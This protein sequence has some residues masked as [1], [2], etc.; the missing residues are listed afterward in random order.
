MKRI[1]VSLSE[2]KPNPYKKFI[3]GGEVDD[4]VVAQIMES[5][6]RTSFWEQW[7]VRETEKGYQLAFGHN[8]LA[9]AKQILGS[10]AK[11]SVQL[12]NYTDSQMYI[13]MADE[14]AGD[15]ESIAHQ[16]DVVRKAKELLIKNTEW[17]KNVIASHRETESN[18]KGAGAPH[19]HGS[20][21]CIQEFLGENNWSRAKVGRLHKLAEQA[22]KSVL[23]KVIDS[24][25]M[26]NENVQAGEI[27]QRAAIA[28]ADLDAPVQRAAAEVIKSAA[29]A[30]PT[31]EIEA[32]VERIATLPSAKQEAAVKREL[33]SKE[34]VQL[35]KKAAKDAKKAAKANGKAVP[36]VPEVGT[37]LEGLG[38]QIKGITENLRELLPHKFAILRN[39]SFKHL[40]KRI[41][42]LAVVM[43]EFSA[44]D[45]P[46]TARV[47]E[48]R[49][50]LT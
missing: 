39:A 45:H 27:S 4:A 33:K 12:E 28:L 43:D 26:R 2:L 47:A 46:T 3:Q 18:P 6:D 8:R 40:A 10:D 34:K 30:I 49:K 1:Q 14:N 36:K 20:V 21:E 5:A 50:Q 9:A 24:A 15:E 17:C 11:V 41:S 16:V 22:D 38:I 31:A 25:K 29:I 19:K 32:V 44:K 7:V 35:G 37:I 48:Q 13:A 23:S 42:E